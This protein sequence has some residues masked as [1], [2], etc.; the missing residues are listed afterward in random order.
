MYKNLGEKQYNYNTEYYKTYMESSPPINDPLD[1]SVPLY[2]NGCNIM[3]G[4]IMP[5]TFPTC[6]YL[7]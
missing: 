1:P 4:F 5:G 2:I 6:D 7:Y 3:Y